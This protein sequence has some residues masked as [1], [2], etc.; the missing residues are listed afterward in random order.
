LLT[1]CEQGLGESITKAHV[2]L[3]P[4]AVGTSVIVIE[5]LLYMLRE[6]KK[7]E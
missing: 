1:F 4:A 5:N 2:A 3:R 7:E 6:L